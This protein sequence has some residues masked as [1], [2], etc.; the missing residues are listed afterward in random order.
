M[1]VRSAQWKAA[2]DGVIGFRR[3]LKQTVGLNVRAEIKAN[4]LLRNS[5]D[6]RTLG[7]SEHARYFIYKGCLQLQGKLGLPAFAI[8]I[9][10]QKIQPNDDP[11]FFAW[12]FLLQR[13][14]RLAT[15]GGGEVLIVHD[16]GEPD[17]VR[18]MARR[19]RRAGLAGSLFGGSV[20]VPFNGLVD[21][22][23]SRNSRHSYF[24]QLADLNAY[25][26]FRCAF[27]P[28]ARTV[29]I[30]PQAMWDELG[31]A[32]YAP[33]NMRKGGPGAGIVLWPK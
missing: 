6:F 11:M 18:K 16:E 5:G 17:Y 9:D 1:L 28:P 27:P 29:Q 21:D 23:V 2:F 19:A 15:K 8:V 7:L 31:P 10:K 14:E 32:K 13:L 26:A 3:F 33:A 30:V 12:T 25:A 24:L 22:P 4:A 20:Q